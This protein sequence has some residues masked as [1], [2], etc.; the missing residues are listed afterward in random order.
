MTDRTITI[1]TETG[2]EILCEILFT[3]HSDEFNKDY[4]VFVKKDTNEASATSYIPGEN[5]CGRLEAIE[6][7][8]EWAM[9]EQLLT[10]YVESQENGC[11]GGCQSCGGSCSCDAD[12]ECDCE[13]GC[14]CDNE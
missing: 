13:N 11:Q 3:H 7:D 1:T 8:E 10:D 2:E 6:T 5:G 12:G 4:V 14:N 9:L